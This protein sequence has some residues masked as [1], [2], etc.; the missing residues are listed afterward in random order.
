MPSLTCP[1]A[2]RRS[3]NDRVTLLAWSV[4]LASPSVNLRQRLPHKVREIFFVSNPTFIQKERRSSRDS[5][6][7]ATGHIA[8]DSLRIGPFS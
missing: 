8:I 4:L 2:D 5:V 6:S 7:S 3:S 1:P